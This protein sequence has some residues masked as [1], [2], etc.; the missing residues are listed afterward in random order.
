[1]P[2]YICGYSCPHIFDSIV[3]GMPM[4]YPDH[5]I[6][7]IRETTDIV[8]LISTYVPLKQS[9]G[10][11]VG[12][13][14]FHSDSTPSFN[15]SQSKQ[16]YHCFGC[17]AGGNVYSFVMAIESL[18]FPT[19]I[20]HLAERIN[21]VLP[22]KGDTP[23]IVSQKDTLYKINTDAARYFYEN[24]KKSEVAIGYVKSRGLTA[25]TAKKFGLGYSLDS[26]DALH[27]HLLSKGYTSDLIEKTGL[28]SKS[29][30]GKYYDRFRGRLMFPI[31]NLR[32]KII[33]FGARALGDEQPKY[34]NSPETPLYSKSE[35]LYGIN[36]AKKN[37]ESEIIVVEGYMD[38][39]ALYQAGFYNVVASLGTSFTSTHGKTLERYAKTV[40]LIF[41]GDKAGETAALRAIS[42]LKLTSLNIKILSLTNAKDPDEY[43]K[44]FSKED[45]ALEI[46]NAKNYIDF[47]IEKLLQTYDITNVAQKIE[48]TKQA[49]L[50]ISHIRDA[51]EQDAYINN[52]SNIANISGNAIRTQLGNTVA[53]APINKPKPVKIANRA[54]KEASENIICTVAYSKAVYTAVHQHLSPSELDGTLYQ[55]ALTHLY[56]LY[57][58]GETVQP[59]RLLNYFPDKQDQQA[60]TSIISR[61]P[62]MDTKYLSKAINDQVKLI[63]KHH[64]DKQLTTQDDIH[65]TQNLINYRKILE[66]LNITLI[67]G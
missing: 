31:F 15:V 63:K 6:E 40:V 42:V 59:A 45:L 61:E 56:T 53:G 49:A 16:L 11:Y 12:L 38:A 36:F 39:I 8:E 19:A 66:N 1:M 55:Q 64:L 28:C 65:T 25:T 9:G 4:S 10:S 35:S 62:N 34:L 7:D 23:A 52:I 43:I 21:Y 60:I 44:K 26:W 14:P 46:K 30:N 47:Q 33:G 3:K 5:I 32:G 29:K 54:I 13:C 18:D 57:E 37:L 24:L 41:D 58:Q 2:T 17:G 22:T 27:N 50:T 51:I 48:F 67:D 20:T